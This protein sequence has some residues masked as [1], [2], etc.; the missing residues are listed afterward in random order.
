MGWRFSIYLLPTFAAGAITMLL[1]LYAWRR[2]TKRAALPFTVF[3]LGLSVWSLGYGIELGFTALGPMLLWDKVAFVGSVIVPTAWFLLAVEYA[4]HDTWLSR[5]RVALLAVEPIATLALVWTNEFHGL[6]WRRAAIDSTG[7]ITTPQF[8]FG[9]AYWVNFG[10]SYLLILVG[11]ALFVRVM[12]H[13]NRLFRRQSLVMVLGAIG[14]LGVNAV[15]NVAPRLNPVGNLDLTTFALA[16][17]GVFFALALFHFRIFGLTPAARDS[18]IEGMDDGILIL[19]AEDRIVDCNPIARRALGDGIRGKA[20]SRT[21]IGPSDSIDRNIESFEVDEESR[22]YEV[23]ETRLT[24]FRGE[25]VGR[26]VLLRDVT[27]LQILRDHE[28]RLSVLNRILRH[29]IRNELTVVTGHSG[30]L[31][32]TVAGEHREHVEAIDRAATRILDMSEKARHVQ[33]T[34]GSDRVSDR[35]VDVAEIA[36]ATAERL[37]KAHPTAEVHVDAPAVAWVSA[38]GHELLEVAVENIGKNAIVHNPESGP[39]V[40]FRIEK[41]RRTTRITV[42]DDG[43]GI[44]ESELAAIESDR[45]TDLEHGSGLGLWLARWIVDASAGELSVQSDGVSGNVISID[46]PRK[47]P[48]EESTTT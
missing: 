13:A 41:R 20:L 11:I 9:P 19:D 31:L 23:S 15:F 4:G 30:L 24:D 28:Q 47:E 14:P 21:A 35:S 46:L 26:F 44:P 45:E 22:T 36:T 43:P 8:A 34:I 37:A 7:P 40:W 48:A 5:K 10:Y 1:A 17:S 18:L 25:T 42:A 16:V 39:S 2:R 38:V 3:L 12:L 27:T 29:N 6:I 32:E 33:G